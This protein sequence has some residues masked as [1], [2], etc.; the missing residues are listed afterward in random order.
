MIFQSK[1]TEKKKRTLLVP[2]DR[3]GFVGAVLRANKRIHCQVK[4]YAEN[5]RSF[6]KRQRRERKKLDEETSSDT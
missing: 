4:E 3:V 6:A 1:Y 5:N 2:K